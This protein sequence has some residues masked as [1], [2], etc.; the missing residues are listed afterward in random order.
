MQ[1]DTGPSAGSIPP[2]KGWAP[3]PGPSGQPPRCI[4][5][6]EGDAAE[7][8][9]FDRVLAE[10]A[11]Q[12]SNVTDEQFDQVVTGCL[13]AL[14]EFLAFDRS[15]L[16]AF[17]EHGS[18]F[19]VTHSWAVEGVPVAPNDVL[20]DARIPWF[21]HQIRSGHIVTV[22]SSSDLPA[23]AAKER[24]YLLR[25]GLKSVLAT[26]LLMEGTIVGALAFSSFRSHR[27]WSLRLVSRLR[28]AGE[29]L[30][31]GIRRHQYAQGLR[32][33]ALTMDQVS[34]D[35]A[36]HEERA[37]K[38]F[39]DRAMRLM[40][41]EHQ[42]RRRMGLVLHEDVMQILAAVGMYVRAGTTDAPQ[43]PDSAKALALL[44]DAMQKL[45]ELTLELRPEA[46]FDMNLPAGIR[47]LADQVRRRYDLDVDVRID[48]TVG[49]VSDDVRSFLYDSTRKLL[50]NVAV[51]AS[52]NRATLD[53][54]PSDPDHIQLTVSDEGVGF[55]PASLQNLPSVGFGLFSIR[56][57][58]ELLGGTLEVN[59]S[60]GKGT[61]AMV[62]VP[63]SDR[64]PSAECRT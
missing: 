45:R 60:P 4:E 63:L 21:T 10:M 47:W 37:A 43:S 39:R 64:A 61:G 49:P 2:A 26:P 57:Q 13:R 17:S 38:H 35:H 8:A 6:S 48:D 40:Q 3:A 25:S 18:R 34:P 1:P 54:R 11:S 55:N 24:S 46:V 19:Q 53:I 30:A 59:G 50:E 23:V 27:R 15:T 56:E 5:V 52:C 16:M 33:I 7:P 22:S 28:L 31:L 29:I 14:V 12:L 20:L 51:H 42:E 9:E 36:G 44:K 62:T 32:N 41:A 58:A